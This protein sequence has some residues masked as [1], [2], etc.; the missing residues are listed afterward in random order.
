MVGVLAQGDLAGRSVLWLIE[1]ILA[2]FVGCG[3]STRRAAAAYR[4]VW[5]YTVGVLT[6]RYAMARRA[7]EPGAGRPK[8][9]RAT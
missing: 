9:Q 3:L 4:V 2:G 1:E 5:Q 6:I 7:D 8:V